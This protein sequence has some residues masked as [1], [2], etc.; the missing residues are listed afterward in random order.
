LVEQPVRELH[1]VGFAHS[2]DAATPVGDCVVERELDDPARAGDRDRLDRDRRIGPNLALAHLDDRLRLFGSEVEL[3]PRVEVLGILAHDHQI[4]VLV[5]GPNAGV[6]FARPHARVE[7]EQL[8]QRHVHAAETLS[9]GRGNRAFERD[10][11]APDAIEDL[12]RQRRAVFVHH[13]HARL[14]DF[15]LYRDPCRLDNPPRRLRYLR[16]SAVSRDKRN[17]VRQ[18]TDLQAR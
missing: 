2:R 17:P 10:L 6:V 16:P 9:D 3:D 12:V 7:I 5:L 13:V 1:D 18:P 11:V 15:P 8:S 4:D 14:F